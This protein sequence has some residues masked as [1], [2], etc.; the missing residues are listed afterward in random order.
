MAFSDACM[1]KPINLLCHPAEGHGEEL[2]AMSH[3]MYIYIYNNILLLRFIL[4]GPFAKW[5]VNFF[6]VLSMT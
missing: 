1:R 6:G 2:W 4:F 3:G 5:L